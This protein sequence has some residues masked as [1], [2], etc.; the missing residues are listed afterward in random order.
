MNRLF[1]PG[2]ALL[3]AMALAACG[4]PRAAAIEEIR[5]VSERWEAALVA[6]TPSSAVADVFTED[7]LRMPAGSPPV[8]GRS[9]IAAA[10]EGAVPLAEA[11]FDLE[12]VG[13]EGDVAY[14]AGSYR[15]RSAAG[16]QQTGKFLEVWR[17]TPAGWR[18]H[19]VMWD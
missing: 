19:R 4:S 3:T 9:A 1:S 11:S 10:L 16:D 18:I 12:D 13:V 15:V 5:E 2:A 8:R 17:R 7:A 14:A 6:G